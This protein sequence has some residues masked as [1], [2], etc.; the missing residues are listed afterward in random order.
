[1]IISDLCLELFLLVMIGGNKM[2]ID[3]QFETSDRF[4]ALNVL[5][6]FRLWCPGKSP[7]DSYLCMKLPSGLDEFGKKFN[8]IILP[9]RS[10]VTLSEKYEAKL[11]FVKDSD[12]V[13]PRSSILT[14]KD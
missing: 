3:C 10:K 6:V 12:F 9:E 1:M 2:V 13:Y 4:I 11:I 14:V 8:A 5:D 7:Y